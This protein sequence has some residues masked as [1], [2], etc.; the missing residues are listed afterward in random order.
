ML[1]PGEEGHVAMASI[2]K[3]DGHLG[4]RLSAGL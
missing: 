4:S 3:D 2:A 1:R